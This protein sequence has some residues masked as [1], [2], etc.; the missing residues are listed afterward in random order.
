MPLTQLRWGLLGTA[1]IHERLI[2]AIRATPRGTIAAVASRDGARAAKFARQWSIPRSYGSYDEL[3]ADR[4]IDV[5]YNPLPNSLHAEWSVRAAALGKHVLCEK[6]LACTV[7][8]VDR[9]REAAARHGVVIQ[10]AAMMR[11]HPQTAKLRELV[12]A[13]TIGELRCVRG[14]FAFVL[15]RAGDIRFDRALGGGSLWDL[16]SYCVSFMR[17]VLGQESHEVH[18]WQQSGPAGADTSFAGHLRFPNGVFGEFFSSFETCPHIEADLL[19]SAG[20]IT[21]DVPWGSRPDAVS[22][23]RVWS[24][25]D[26]GPQGTFSDASDSLRYEEFAFERVNAYCEQIA[27]MTATLLDG[28]PPVITLA[29]SRANVATLEALAR[30]AAEGASV[31]MQA[32]DERSEEALKKGQAPREV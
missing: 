32:P 29:D 23:I 17:T 20:R 24:A 15:S 21:L 13:K 11:F 28:A 25:D 22:R 31:K 12:A 7:Q 1:R 30:S 5:I 4:E 6:P 14:V 9:M 3:L 16:G 18:G 10:E 8:E 2:P 26:S 27:S 19:G